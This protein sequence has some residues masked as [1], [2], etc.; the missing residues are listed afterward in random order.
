[1]P[2]LEFDRLIEENNARSEKKYISFIDEAA[3]A[4]LDKLRILMISKEEAKS[5]I[6]IYFSSKRLA[7]ISDEYTG[8]S[9][10][11]GR[12]DKYA[13]Y[14]DIYERMSEKLEGSNYWAE[15]TIMKDCPDSF[16][17]NFSV[18][19]ISLTDD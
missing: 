17:C 12:I 7:E 9:L 10:N 5:K 19:L 2:E 11:D 6:D 1:M 14:A 18:E 13:V 3:D 15:K 4:V 8:G 16:E